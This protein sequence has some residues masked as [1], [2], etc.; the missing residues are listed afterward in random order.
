MIS[1][2]ISF[3]GI[4]F[5]LEV[6]VAIAENESEEGEVSSTFSRGVGESSQ[7]V[8]PNPISKDAPLGLMTPAKPFPSAN[9]QSQFKTPRPAAPLN[10]TAPGL[11]PA[12]E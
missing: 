6:E 8:P 9:C 3:V 2:C 7:S 11:R 5:G 12:S 10:T 4:C 1:G